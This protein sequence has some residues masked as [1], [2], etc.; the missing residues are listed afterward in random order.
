MGS[1]AA[2]LFLGTIAQPLEHATP[3]L[4]VVYQ[5]QS[6]CTG[7]DSILTTTTPMTGTAVYWDPNLAVDPSTPA[8]QLKCQLDAAG[9]AA[10]IGLS[11]VFATTCVSLPTGLPPSIKDYFGPVQTMNLVVPQNSTALSI[12]AEAAYFVYGFGAVQNLVSPWISP[13]QIFQRNGAA[14]IQKLIGATIGVPA[15]NWLGQQTAGAGAMRTAL[16]N[17][18]GM[19][20]T[21][22]NESIG[23]LSADL[24]DPS[25]TNVH[26]LAFQDYNQ[27]C[28]F[29]PD[30]TAMAL[31][32]ANVRDGHFANFGPLHMLTHVSAGVPTSANATILLNAITGVAPPAGVDIIDLYAKHSLVPQC[33]MRVTRDADGGAIKPFQPSPGCACYFRERATALS[34]PPG[35]TTCT[36]AATCPASAPNCNKFAAQT[37]GYCEP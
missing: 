14:G 32:K 20:A 34:P 30:S 31:D 25:R 36:T 11:D 18:G 8:A 12:S 13:S 22:A 27:S 1:A 16:I 23:I 2:A 29:Y 26:Q 15:S 6:S 21:F 5:T 19:G 17:A 24:A 7:I 9:N 10:D 28:A 35:C 4:T 33:A 37:S 3:P